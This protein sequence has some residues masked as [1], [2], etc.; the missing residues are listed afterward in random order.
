MS[1]EENILSNNNLRR[2]FFSFQVYKSKFKTFSPFS[3]FSY[4]SF[5]LRSFLLENFQERL[6]F[7]LSLASAIDT[8]TQANTDK[9]PVS[10]SEY[11]IH[12][13]A[14]ISDYSSLR[15]RLF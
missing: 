12:Y 11:L 8:Y 1:S 9:H 10:Y 15:I 7:I 3:R 14:H 5:F 13:H 4:V 2:I 6:P